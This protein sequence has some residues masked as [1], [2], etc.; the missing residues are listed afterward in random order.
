MD[1]NVGKC[2]DNPELADHCA[3]CCTQVTGGIKMDEKVESKLS[4]RIC[5]ESD[6][7]NE[8]ER[9]YTICGRCLR[10]SSH[11]ASEESIRWKVEQKNIGGVTLP[12]MNKIR[13]MRAMG[14]SD[15]DVVKKLI[16][17]G[18]DE[19]MRIKFEFKE[20]EQ[21]HECLQ[22]NE[23]LKKNGLREMPK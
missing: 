22:K 5:V 1:V 3:W 9:G 16:L 8:P 12:W 19:E 10:G 18:L 7:F 13:I 23:L 6:C 17:Y 2:K 11:K 14:L 15:E 20:R 4:E 21:E